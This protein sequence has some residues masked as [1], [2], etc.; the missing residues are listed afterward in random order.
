MMREG[1]KDLVS[2]G[3]SAVIELLPQGITEGGILQEGVPETVSSGNALYGT[4]YQAVYDAVTASQTVTDGQ[5]VNSTAL[6]YFK[7]I[8]GNQVLP[9]DYVIYVGEEYQYWD[10]N[11]QRSAYEYCMAYGDLDCSGTWF[12]GTGTVCSMRTQGDIVVAYEY[13]QQINLQAPLYYSRSNLG[14]YSG[15]ITYDWTGILL[16]VLVLIGGLV[17]LIRKLLCIKY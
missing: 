13:D 6:N 8:L 12:S 11:R 10:G 4:M 7:G 2:S 3:D 5:T 17:W 9:R 15:V 1:G 16:L 14:D